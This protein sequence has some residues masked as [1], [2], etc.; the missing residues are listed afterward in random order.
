MG[1]ILQ[2]TRQAQAVK[3]GGADG[4][5]GAADKPNVR[6]RVPQHIRRQDARQNDGQRGAE[7]PHDVVC[8]LQH[9]SAKHPP[10]ALVRMMHTTFAEYPWVKPPSAS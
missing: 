6:A 10:K 8:I 1:H 5:E 9:C 4:E 7:A 3:E 2:R